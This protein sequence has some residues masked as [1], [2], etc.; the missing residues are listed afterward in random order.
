MILF[1]ETS[2]FPLYAD[3]DCMGYC[4]SGPN[5]E[6]H[7]QLKCIMSIHTVAHEFAHY[8]RQEQMKKS[9]NLIQ[10]IPYI[11]K[12]KLKYRAL[13]LSRKGILSFPVR[14]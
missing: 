12:V 5:L 8:E 7:S 13:G 11:R 2:K 4:H 14:F 9:S 3:S 6:S 10:P 1:K